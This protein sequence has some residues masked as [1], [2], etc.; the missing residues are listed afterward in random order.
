MAKKLDDFIEGLD[1][2]V[3]VRKKAG[4]FT[5]DVD[6]TAQNVAVVAK[7]KR[8]MAGKYQRVQFLLPP[9]QVDHINNL[10]DQFGMSRVSFQRWL[11]D[12]ALLSVERGVRPEVEVRQVQGE[13][14]K[15]HWS[16]Q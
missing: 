7:T 11:V 16:S 10:A 3:V 1:T 12:Q 6:M 5:A 13:A 14:K 4:D 8:T 2:P 9:A 15:G